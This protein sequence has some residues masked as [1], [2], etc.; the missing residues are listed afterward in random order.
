MATG[1]V[2]K[3]KKLCW[4]CL[5]VAGFAVQCCGGLVGSQE[6]EDALA[7]CRHPFHIYVGAT[8]AATAA[9]LPVGRL[10]DEEYVV[11]TVGNGL[12]LLG[13]DAD[14]T[15]AEAMEVRKI[16]MRGT[17]YAVY[18]FLENEMGVKWLWPGDT[19]RSGGG[20]WAVGGV[21]ADVCL[22]HGRRQRQYHRNGLR[23]CGGER[24][25]GDVRQHRVPC[26]FRSDD[27]ALGFPAQGVRNRQACAYRVQARAVRRNR[28]A[29]NGGG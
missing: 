11:K 16:A 9:G 27:S 5:A 13:G 4:T 7:P 21:R 14:T 10:A 1:N 25:E 6:N 8:K 20:Q 19:V 26:R 12:Y 18:D 23:Q 3:S 17:L 24:R 22:A 29:C 15:Y 28:L 2:F